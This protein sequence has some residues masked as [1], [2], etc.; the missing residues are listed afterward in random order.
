MKDHLAKTIVVCGALAAV[1]GLLISAPHAQNRGAA[2]AEAKTRPTPRLSNG[3][4]DFSGFYGGRHGDETGGALGSTLNRVDGGSLYFEYGAATEGAGTVSLE[5]DKNQPVYK[6]EYMAKVNALADEMYGGNSNDDPQHDCK[7]YG[8]PRAGIGGYIMHTPEAVAILYEAAPG[9]FWRLIYTDGRKHPENYDTSYFGHSVGHWEG[10]T[11]VVDT[12]G[13]N[14]ETWLAASQTG[15]LK[16]TTLHSDQLH[17]VERI[18]R[19]GDVL[20]YQTTVEDPIMFQKPWVL[21]PRSAR[22]NRSDDYIQPQMCK[23]N[24]KGHLMKANQNPD[25]PNLKCGWCVSDQVYGGESTLPT[26]PGLQDRFKELQ[27]KGVVKSAPAPV[28]K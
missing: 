20:T 19:V 9:P 13:L 18:T 14:D 2:V 28:K 16:H 6:P 24:D 12:I 27:E 21:E 5:E 8:I 15:N 3:H 1:L 22:I 4:P 17:T 10:D 26:A 23:N 7:P 11:L 25:D